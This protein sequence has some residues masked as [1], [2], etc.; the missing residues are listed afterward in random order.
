[1]KSSIRIILVV[2][3]SAHILVGPEMTFAMEA[4]TTQLPA[5]TAVSG[6]RILQ[7][8]QSGTWSIS[9]NGNL[10]DRLTYGVHWGDEISSDSLVTMVPSPNALDVTF[11]HSYKNDGA[12]KATFIVTNQTGAGTAT[13]VE[14]RVTGFP[15]VSPL[16]DALSTGYGSIGTFMTVYGSG[17]SAT[18]NLV[19]F[20]DYGAMMNVNS[21]DGH[22]L[23]FVVPQYI[24]PACNP[25]AACPQYGQFLRSGAY[26]ISVSNG[27]IRSNSVGFIVQ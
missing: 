1:M 5:I 27:F 25:N 15:Q 11:S 16:L 6:P 9:A 12:Y 20:D 4:P 22:T 21:Y 18:G 13:D 7:T 23:Y 26:Q 2:L 19:Y 8:N 24:G 14:F 3:L 17:F 10:G